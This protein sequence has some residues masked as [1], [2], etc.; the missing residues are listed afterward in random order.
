MKDA[1]VDIE[2]GIP[3]QI[4]CRWSVLKKQINS[5]KNGFKLKDLLKSLQNCYRFDT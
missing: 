4:S 1:G 5:F 3:F 2:L